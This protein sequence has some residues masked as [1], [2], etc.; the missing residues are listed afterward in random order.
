MIIKGLTL[1]TIAAAGLT[2]SGDCASAQ[3]LTGAGAIEYV[4]FETIDGVDDA[5]VSRVAVAVNQTLTDYD[6]FVGRFVSREED[7]TWIEVVYWRDLAAAK[8]SLDRFVKDPRNAEFLAMVDQ[9]S[10]TL[11]YSEI[12]G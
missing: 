8:A 7:G 4:T 12:E 9:E 10:I 3:D 2:F 6:G 1:G 5:D 11:N